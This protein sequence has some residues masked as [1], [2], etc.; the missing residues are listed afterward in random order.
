MSNEHDTSHVR[1]SPIQDRLRRVMDLVVG[2]TATI[3]FA[4]VMLLCALAILV[5]SG[6]PVLFAQER[7]GKGGRPFV[8]Y[9]FRKF[10]KSSVA[11]CSLTTRADSRLNIVGRILLAT[12]FDE[13]PQLFNVIRGDM[14]IIGPRPESLAFAD[15]FVGGFERVLD[16]KPGIFGP[17]QTLFRNESNLYPEGADPVAFYRARLFPMKARIDLAYYPHRTLPSDALWL[18]RSVLA[19]FG[20]VPP[21]AVGLGQANQ[22]TASPTAQQA[23]TP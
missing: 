11:G 5:E 20:H 12:K 21:L 14:S 15:C 4:P 19:V 10:A 2:F 23:S 7:L 9:K 6:G 18:I 3:V 16:H 8:M 13:L 17:C 22:E 1:S